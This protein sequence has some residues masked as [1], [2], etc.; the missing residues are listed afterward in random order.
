[1]RATEMRLIRIMDQRKMTQRP[2]GNVLTGTSNWRWKDANAAVVLVPH[3]GAVLAV[4][5]ALALT[6]F[7][8]AE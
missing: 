4:P 7:A 5:I 6:G 1:M 3:T 2:R 8:T